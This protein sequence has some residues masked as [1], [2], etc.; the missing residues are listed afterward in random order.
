MFFANPTKI[1]HSTLAHLSLRVKKKGD[2]YKFCLEFFIRFY[3]C[4]FNPAFF[5]PL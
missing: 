4:V 2:Q 5:S 1:S 3:V